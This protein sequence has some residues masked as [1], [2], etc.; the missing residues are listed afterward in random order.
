MRLRPELVLAGTITLAFLVAPA[1]TTTDDEASPRP[2][3][4]SGGTVE[5]AGEAVPVSVLTDAVGSLCT[6]RDQSVGGDKAGAGATFFDRAHDPMHTVARALEEVDRASAARVLEAKESVEAD[7][8]DTSTSPEALASHLSELHD[9]AAAG[10]L[11]LQVE[12][13]PCEP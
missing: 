10:L 3:A 1:C 4:R 5:V 7:L 11:R 9:T 13:Q 8:D 6:A 2:T 12:V